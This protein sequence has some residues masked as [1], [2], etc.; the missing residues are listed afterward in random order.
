MLVR[1][2]SLSLIRRRVPS[3]AAEIVAITEQAFLDVIAAHTTAAVEGPMAPVAVWGS[4]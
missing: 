1:W 3:E 4:T 2:D